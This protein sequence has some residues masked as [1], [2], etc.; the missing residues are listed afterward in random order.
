MNWWMIFNF[1]SCLFAGF[2]AGA[3]FELRHSKKALNR[4]W[5]TF[6]EFDDASQKYSDFLYESVKKLSTENMELKNENSALLCG[7][8]RVLQEKID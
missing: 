8:D 4:M 3:L 5:N 1:A 2:F 7:R 6:K